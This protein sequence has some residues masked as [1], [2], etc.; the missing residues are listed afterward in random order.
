[1]V[2]KNMS[3]G[4]PQT[5]NEEHLAGVAIHTAWLSRSHSRARRTQLWLGSGSALAERG[6]AVS[7]RI[8]PCRRTWESQGPLSP[9]M[10]FIL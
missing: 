3:D 5:G 4:P 7:Y 2:G 1:M 10:D 9:K 6:S 8:V